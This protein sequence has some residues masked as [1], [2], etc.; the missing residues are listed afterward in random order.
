LVVENEDRLFAIAED[1]GPKPMASLSPA[2]QTFKMVWELEAEVNN[3]GFDQYF[4][5]SSGRNAPRVEAA[6]RAIGASQCADI[7]ARALEIVSVTDLDWSDDARRQA[8]LADMAASA[9]DALTVLDEKFYDYPDA[10]GELLMKF[11]GDHPKEFQLANGR[12]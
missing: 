3:G 2:Q 9:E 12:P 4:L 10:L 6:L 1:I 11:V 8:H 5:N 7:A